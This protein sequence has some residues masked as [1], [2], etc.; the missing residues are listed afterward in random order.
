M[1]N[2]LY[3][4]EKQALTD[5]D[6]ICI[7]VPLYHCFGMVI[8]NLC[9][10]NYAS[11]MVY[12]SEGFDAGLAL[13]ACEKEKCTAL[14]GVPT[15]FVAMLEEHQRKPREVASLRT[16]VI[17]GSICAEP[18]MKRIN[19]ELKLPDLTNCYGMTETSPVTFQTVAA[20]PFEKKVT[21]VGK[22]HPNVECKIIDEKGNI[23]PRGMEGEICTR[24]YVVMQKY[25]AEEEKTADAI[26][27]AGWMHTGDLGIVDEEGYLSIVGRV[28][29]MIIRGG[30]NIY[31][32]EIEE[33]MGHFPEV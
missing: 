8:G 22:V 23:L 29:D 14:Y 5:Q 1:N 31:P 13:D 28:K 11:T 27:S 9:A 10:L 21:T 16:G 6:K 24:G 20:D 7:T 30:E 3:I 4:G 12:P 15:M 26:D 32:K 18:L 33:F 25:W 17:A 19:S 2:S